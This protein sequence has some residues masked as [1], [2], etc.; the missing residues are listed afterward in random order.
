MR[1]NFSLFDRAWLPV[2][3]DDGR[4]VFVRPRDVAGEVEGRPIVRIATGR[5]DCD[6]SL[7]ELLIGL[8]AVA[9]APKSVREWRKRFDQPPSPAELQAAFEPFGNA[10][11]LDGP[12]P[13]F[14]QDFEAFNG[15][16][17]SVDALFIDAPG[18]NTLK[19]NA[20]HFVKRGRTSVLSRAGAVIAL[21]SLQISAPSGGA[22]H[23]TSPRG[24]GPLTTMIQ[25]GARNGGPP[26]LW[27]R[28]WANVPDAEGAE[29]ETSARVFPWLAKTRTSD[30]KNAGIATTPEDVHPLQAF[31]GM[32]RRIRLVF[33]DNVDCLP[34]DL[35]GIVDDVI[36]PG[37]VTKPWGVNYSAWSRGHPMSPYYKTK[38]TDAEFLPLHLKSSRV[39][40]RQ[41]L[42]MVLEAQKG[43]RI[44]AKCLTTWLRRAQNFEGADK[45]IARDARL[46]VAGFA[47]DNMKPLD[48]AEE[49]LP[50]VVTGDEHCDEEIRNLAH[51][52]V[53]AADG[54]ASQLV[55][56]TKLAMFGEKAKAE[57][58][59]TVLDAVKSRFW[60]DSEA[61]FYNNLR[62][63]SQSVELRRDDLIDAIDGLRARHGA[64]WLGALRAVCLGVF[65]TTAPID[66]ADGDRIADVIAG[67]KMLGLMFDGYG[68]AGA[69]L[70]DSL[71]QPPVE[72][73]GKS[74]R[75]R[76]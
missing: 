24:G 47:M 57:R 59:S 15:E 58:D 17:N 74:G 28:L 40:Y 30:P 36:V 67:R 39:G 3:L 38:E 55:S 26:S 34:C 61:G 42:G 62:E 71:S 8:L 23:R 76:A 69:A 72:A 10:F 48:Y 20:D 70:F 18:G 14:F 56:A 73:G 33:Q 9:Y 5:P 66:D 45:A 21:A 68:K 50:L 63:I 43:L 53:N 2:A 52:W 29:L 32:P 12:G 41:W 16:A 75:K 19:E 37:Y 1:E 35:L 44:P 25:P 6:T 7:A 22:G 65:D 4:R 49:L 46:L 60:A 27:Q 11:L 54:A 13:R 31:F 64:Q 51:D